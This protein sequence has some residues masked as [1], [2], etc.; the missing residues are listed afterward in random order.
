MIGLNFMTTKNR[1]NIITINQQRNLNGM[2]LNFLMISY[3]V[4]A[5]YVKD[6]ERI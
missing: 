5:N 3:L 2:L 4:H 1:D 6:G